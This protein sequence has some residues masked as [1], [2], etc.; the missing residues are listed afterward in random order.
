MPHK[1]HRV[2]ILLRSLLWDS[3]MPDFIFGDGIHTKRVVS[4]AYDTSTGR[5]SLV[6]QSVIRNNQ[7]S[8]IIFSTGR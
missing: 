3:V 2:I 5:P 6:R 7:L 8:G 1:L 4:S